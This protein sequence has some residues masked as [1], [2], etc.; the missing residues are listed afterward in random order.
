[1]RYLLDTHALLWARGAPD[2]L[3]LEALMALRSPENAFYVSIASLWECA[4]KSSLGK[5]D[6]PPEFYR[7]VVEDYTLLAIEIPHLEAYAA[8]PVHHR[9]PFD[10]LLIAQARLAGLTVITR[11]RNIAKYDVPVMAA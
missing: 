9:D 10:R 2:R 5:L 3:S 8:L 6:I 1:M 11:D 4:I 7:T